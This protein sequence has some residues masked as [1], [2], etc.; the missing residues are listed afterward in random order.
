MEDDFRPDLLVG[1]ILLIILLMS[2]ALYFAPKPERH[3]IYYCWDNRDAAAIPCKFRN[4]QIDVS[5]PSR[6]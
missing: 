5:I 1:V 4:D 2:A 6:V 3:H